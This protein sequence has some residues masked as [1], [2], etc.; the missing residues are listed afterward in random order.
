MIKYLYDNDAMEK[1]SIW[2]SKR[3]SESFKGVIGAIDRWLFHIVRPGWRR[4]RC[5]NPVRFFSRKGF[6]CI[7][8]QCIV[9]DKK[10]IIWVSYNYQGENHDF[11]CSRDTKLHGFLQNIR[12]CLHNRGGFIL[13][14]SAYSLE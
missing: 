12:A 6:Y 13:G 14:G 11:S 9:D 4:N 10:R 3:Y 2:F 8:V 7:N 5:A 1:A